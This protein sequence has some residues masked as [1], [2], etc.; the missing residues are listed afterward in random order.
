MN[1]PKKKIVLAVP[2]D[3]ALPAV[4]AKAGVANIWILLS[5]GVEAKSGHAFRSA[6]QIRQSGATGVA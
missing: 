6:Y 3:A 5:E 1:W 2:P 4:W